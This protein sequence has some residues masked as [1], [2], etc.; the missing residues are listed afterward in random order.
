MANS[1]VVQTQ[2]QPGVTVVQPPG[3]GY[4]YAA[5]MM[6]PG[7]PTVVA[8]QMTPGVTSVPQAARYDL[9]GVRKFN[10]GLCDCCNDCGV[11]CY[12]YCCWS[13]LACDVAKSLDEAIFYC[14]LSELYRQKIRYQYRIQGSACQDF[15]A[16][17]WC[18]VCSFCQMYRE[19][20]YYDNLNPCWCCT[21]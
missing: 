5:P 11:C 12:G 20:K 2:A 15:C 8:Q 1:Y 14:C 13:C 17:H 9:S 3:V 21:C 10:S 18:C 7:Q 6:Q 4:A 16:I 19:L